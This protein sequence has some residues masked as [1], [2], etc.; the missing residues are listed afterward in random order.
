MICSYSLRTG[1]KAQSPWWATIMIYLCSK[2][3]SDYCFMCP[4]TE[5]PRKM[6]TVLRA[7]KV[8][9]RNFM[10]CTCVK[11][12]SEE[13]TNDEIFFF[14]NDINVESEKEKE[15]DEVE[16]RTKCGKYIRCSFPKWLHFIKWLINFVSF[17]NQWMHEKCADDFIC[18]EYSPKQAQ[19]T[20]IHLISCSY[21]FLIHH[22]EYNFIWYTPSIF[23]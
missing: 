20:I 23:S 11:E 12:Q 9:L 2:M 15:D 22:H 3:C 14:Q 10:R 7:V 16:G 18:G 21:M 6:D 17:S 5:G 4:D 19:V 1:T 8:S 13:R